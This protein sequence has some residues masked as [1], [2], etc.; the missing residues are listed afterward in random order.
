MIYV[1]PR[2]T[3]CN[4]HQYGPSGNIELHDAICLLPLNILNEKI[5]I[6]QWFFFVI[7]SALLTVQLLYRIALMCSFRLRARVLYL[8]NRLV[9]IEALREFSKN[10]SRS[11]WWIMYV[12]SQNMDPYIY[13]DL[14]VEL[15]GN[16]GHEQHN[17]NE[18]ER[19]Q[20]VDGLGWRLPALTF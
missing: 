10:S 13:R 5:F 16:M 20:V 14:L 18:D 7:M 2:I 12:L 19:S 11:N 17:N 1:F 6:F 9:P 4:F 3:K 15:L 8:S